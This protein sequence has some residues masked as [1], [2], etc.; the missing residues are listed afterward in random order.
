MEETGR[1]GIF[2][3]FHELRAVK[4]YKAVVCEFLAT[5]ILL[6]FICGAS[7]TMEN[8]KPLNLY[9]AAFNAGMAVA[10]IVWTFNHVSG[11]HINPALTFSLF[12]T[13]HVS[14]TKVGCS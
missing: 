5:A 4:F 13:G 9:T 14:L 6:L 3:G 12:A 8:G 7:V 11:A 1:L 2:L 10:F